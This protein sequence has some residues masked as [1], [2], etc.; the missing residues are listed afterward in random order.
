MGALRKSGRAGRPAKPIGAYP[1]L[2]RQSAENAHGTGYAVA[3]GMKSKFDDGALTPNAVLAPAHQKGDEL[4]GKG[5]L[6]VSAIL[7][8]MIKT[9]GGHLYAT[10]WEVGHE[11]RQMADR[12]AHTTQDATQKVAEGIAKTARSMEHRFAYITDGYDERKGAAPAHDLIAARFS[13]RIGRMP[14]T[15][16]A[17]ESPVVLGGLFAVL[18]Y[19][20]EAGRLRAPT[21]ASRHDGL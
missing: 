21:H 9:F 13:N 15:D 3:S 7:G 14:T 11:M 17:G 2:A 20:N 19:R 4:A 12:A 5:N 8:G 18:G 6:L 1:R 16:G 10:A